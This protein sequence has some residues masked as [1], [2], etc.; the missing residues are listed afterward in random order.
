MKNITKTATQKALE[1]KR[2]ELKDIKAT[3]KRAQAAFR[4]DVAKLRDEMKAMRVDIKT[5]KSDDRMY[6]KQVMA[7]QKALRKEKRAQ[8]LAARQEA[9][10]AKAATRAAVKAARIDAIQAKLDALK[11]SVGIQAK[12]PSPVTVKM[13]SGTMLEHI[14][15]MASMMPRGRA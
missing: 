3:A 12:K 8:K 13:G 7:D 4:K 2:Q 5:D 14:E 6:R 1:F 11:N 9:K 15:Q 10:A